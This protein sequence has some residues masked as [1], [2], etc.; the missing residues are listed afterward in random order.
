MRASATRTKGDGRIK[1][2]K[3]ALDPGHYDQTA[4]EDTGQHENDLLALVAFGARPALEPAVDQAGIAL[5]ERQGAEERG[6]REQHA[7]LNTVR[8]MPLLGGETQ[9]LDAFRI[10]S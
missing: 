4:R 8:F 3:K 1:A 9:G 5:E 6:N 7:A 10:I 2:W